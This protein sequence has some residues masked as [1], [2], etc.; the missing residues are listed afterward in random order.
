MAV[1]ART[2]SPSFPYAAGRARDSNIHTVNNE[3]TT[4]ETAG[5]DR[6]LTTRETIFHAEYDST[7][8][9]LS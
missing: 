8:V 5:L 6:R 4:N 1:P 3:A 7:T 2:H 9:L